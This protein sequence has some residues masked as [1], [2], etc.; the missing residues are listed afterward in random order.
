VNQKPAHSMSSAG[1][2]KT[3]VRLPSNLEKALATVVHTGNTTIETGIEAPRRIGITMALLVFGVFGLWSVTAPIDGA[4]LAGGVI[5]VKSYKKVVQ[6]LEGGIV[7]ELRVQNGD[8]VNEGDVLLLLDPTQTQAQLEIYSGQMLSLT[9]LEAR[10]VA[11]RDNMDSV[12]YPQ[13]LTNA[14]AKAEV[15]T[16]AQNQIFRARKASREGSIAVLEQRISQLQQRVTGLNALQ[17][18][19]NTLADSFADELQDTRALLAEGFADKLR[20]RELERNHASLSG[21]AAELATTIASTEIQ[22]G[23]TRLQILQ[24]ENEFQ[25]QV[26]DQLSQTQNQLKDT[27]ERVNA[28]TH[29]VERTEVRTPVAGTVTG[30]Q[31]HTVGG[32]ISPGY[33]IAEI[34]PQSDELVI[35]AQV[36]TIDIDRVSAG[37]EATIRLPTFNSANV[38]TLFGTVLTVSA[39]AMQD[40]TT[41][42][43][44]YLAR[45]EIKPESMSDLQGLVLIPGMPA[46]VLITTGSRTFLQYLMKPLSNAVAR[47]FIED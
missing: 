30:L 36:Q 5:T 13:L 22:V 31:F 38:P 47:S 3:P 4:A 6:H 19:K 27:R 24:I 45:V 15:E 34:V 25:S 41:G 16:T 29:I 39:D 26:V 18:S 11:E 9:A 1:S 23:E 12:A 28:L 17:A 33:P 42:A 35:E 32:V 44:F 8:F 37:Q 7:K 14:G 46:E 10:L 43:M 20:L 40:Q 21:E 2:S